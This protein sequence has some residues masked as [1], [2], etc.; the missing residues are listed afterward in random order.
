MC[1]I[2]RVSFFYFDGPDLALF[3][4]VTSGGVIEISLNDKLIVDPVLELGKGM[5]IGVTRLSG[6]HNIE[7]VLVFVH[8]YKLFYAM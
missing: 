5:N 7:K 4:D 1:F 3:G 6:D 8:S 2:E